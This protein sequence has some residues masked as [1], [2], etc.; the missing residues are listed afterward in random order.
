M[1]QTIT[2]APIV[3]I[4]GV[5]TAGT[6]NIHNNSLSPATV[7]LYAP[8]V[9]PPYIDVEIIYSGQTLSITPPIPSGTIYYLT[10]Y[11]WVFPF[12]P[13]HQT[14]Q[15]DGNTVDVSLPW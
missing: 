2:P 10:A 15:K 4:T 3:P 14:F 1:T 11:S 7:N 9:F 5:V 8:G 13:F 12:P 6:V